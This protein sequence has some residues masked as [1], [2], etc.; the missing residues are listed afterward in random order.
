MMS[1]MTEAGRM[2]MPGRLSAAA[3]RWP[4]RQFV[5]RSGCKTVLLVRV[6][7]TEQQLAFGLSQVYGADEDD[8]GDQPQVLEFNTALVTVGRDAAEPRRGNVRHFDTADLTKWI[9][10]ARCFA[11]PLEQRG[12]AISGRISLGRALNKDLTLRSQNISKLHAWFE[13]DPH[14]TLMVA[15]AGSKNGTKVAGVRL[16][17]RQPV[18]VPAG[19]ELS[20]GPIE[21]TVCPIEHFWDVASVL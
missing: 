11:L 19:A 7:D 14:G 20:F 13:Y 18:S 16:A 15:D 21:A 1:S 9:A 10:R 6:P 2:L 3:R 5:E 12:S 17:P 4:V 8:A